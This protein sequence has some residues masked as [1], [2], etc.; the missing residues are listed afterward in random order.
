MASQAEQEATRA[1]LHFMAQV[2]FRLAKEK[3]EADKL[4]DN[5]T[6]SER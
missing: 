1:L 4:P 5:Q 6:S 2:W 3:E